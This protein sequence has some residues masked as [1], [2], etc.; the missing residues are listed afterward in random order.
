[1]GKKF[2]ERIKGPMDNYEDWYHYDVENDQ[3]IVTHSWSHVSPKLS[4]SSGSKKYTLDEFKISKDV[5]HGAKIA[6]D[7]ALAGE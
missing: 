2:F 5:D 4:S 1:M 7:K 3:V 6:L